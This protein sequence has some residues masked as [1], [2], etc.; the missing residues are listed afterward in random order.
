MDAQDGES[1]DA[2]TFLQILQLTVKNLSVQDRI[3][4]CAAPIN[5]RDSGEKKFLHALAEC[6]ADGK[7]GNLL[8]IESLPLGIMD[9]PASGDRKYLYQ[10][11]QLHK[12]IVC[13]LWLSYRFPNV[14]TT[15]AL[16]N[17]TKK[18]VEDQIEKVLTEFSFIE[19]A[20]ARMVKHRK[21]ARKDIDGLDAEVAA[22]QMDG[23]Q[24]PAPPGMP[25][26]AKD[27]VNDNAALVESPPSTD[28][29]DEYPD[30]LPVT[31]KFDSLAEKHQQ[32]TTRLSEEVGNLLQ[33]RNSTVSS[34]TETTHASI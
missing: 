23:R 20:R 30:D 17:H 33:S 21:Q 28:D 34:P 7:S 13:Y 12:M 6:I 27:I 4:I 3:M 10:L 31:S 24:I 19:Q 25:Q 16:G 5:M 32:R 1:D 2:V 14:F 18:L 11:E 8:D 26:E 15:R 9:Q 29:A 22:Q